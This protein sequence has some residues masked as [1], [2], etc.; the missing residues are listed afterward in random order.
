M[1]TRPQAFCRL[2]L[3]IVIFLLFGLTNSI[4]LP[5]HKA[6]DEIAHFQYTRFIAQHGR[7]PQNYEERAEA[8]YRSDWPAL[9]H[10]VA[11][12]LTGWA[13]SNEPPYLK[14]VWESPRF[15]LARELLDTKRLANTEDEFWPYRGAVLM[16]HLGRLVSLGLA[17]GAIVIVF[18][19]AL[20]VFPNNYQAAVTAAALVAF[21]PTF[22]FIS[23]AMSDD[24]LLALVVGLYTLALIKIFK[25]STRLLS[26]AALGGLMGLSAATKYSAVILP[27]EVLALA[28]YLVWRARWSL[29][30]VLGRVGMAA[31][32]AIIASSWW[33]I[34]LVIY[35]NEIAE[36]GPVVGALKPVIAGG[37]DRSQRYA[38]YV[39][40]G[41]QIGISDSPE[42]ISE[43]FDAWLRQTFQSFWAI[44]VGNYPLSP[45]AYLFVGVILL[46]A[47]VGLARI[48]QHQPAYRRWIGLFLGHMGVF[49]VFPLVRYGILRDLG[50]SAQGRHLLFPVATIFPLLLW[51]GWQGL[52]RF[53]QRFLPAVTIAGLLLWNIAL[54]VRVA[55][56]YDN[57][58]TWLPV[59]TVSTVT[60]SITQP[61]DVP[62]GNHLRLLGYDARL[63]PNQSALALSFYW[64]AASYPDE[65]Y[66]RD[67]RL[68]QSGVPQLVWSTYPANARYPTRLWEPE[69]VIRDDVLLPLSGLEAGDYTLQ[70]Q[71]R[72]A[73][74]PL[75]AL[76]AAPAL[77]LTTLALPAMPPP[78]PNLPLNITIDGREVIGGVHLWQASAYTK[79]DLPEYNPRMTIPLLW[80]SNLASTQRVNWLLIDPA[81]Q[82]YPATTVTPNQIFFQVMPFW[83]SGLYRLRAELWQAE[84]VIASAETPPALRVFNERPR[85]GQLPLA[86]RLVGAS[87]DNKLN[88]LGYDLP[89]RRLEPGQELPVTLY[90]Q[91][92]RT[93]DRSYTVFAKLLD[94]QHQMQS[95]VER[96]PADGYNTI[97]WLEG[98]M[99]VD[100]FAL[101]VPS[102]MPPGVYWLNVGVYD[103]ISGQAVSLPISG[104]DGPS[105]GETSITLDAVKIGGPPPGVVA[106][107]IT[108]AYPQKI[109]F[110]DVI[111]LRGYDVQYTG[112]AVGLTFYWKSLAQTNIDYTVFVHLQNAGGAI[113]AQQDRPLADGVYPSSLWT[114]GE[115]IPDSLALSV[116]AGLPPGTYTIV[117]GLY[118]FAAGRRLPVAVTGKDTITVTT[119]TL[120]VD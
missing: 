67:I 54:T 33:Y 2:G 43:P 48:W 16:W 101:P 68:V 6:P 1:I 12:F 77:T 22:N 116:P 47:A 112:Q 7:L 73:A 15:E 13:D 18:I 74:G 20:Q 62:F 110:G 104:E 70:L 106:S 120:P 56:Y 109:N 114:P 117:A 96:L 115:I 24:S 90:W 53:W 37:V 59:R 4:L 23:S 31:V 38:A 51:L 50:Q 14:F 58:H 19:T 34:F 11:A 5:L 89:V 93:M 60:E 79:L 21:L 27:V 91:G 46:C 82:P 44:N 66:R 10:V 36:Y 55:T 108:P 86:G 80:H 65:D 76:N 72:N 8:G 30:R 85:L 78:P 107:T 57:I 9:Y 98:E 102:N 81:G 45:A 83:P 100:G 32:A 64:R 87:F 49:M 103:Q 63:Q 119:L 75:P 28:G 99:V 94:H 41:G 69:E 88:L 26:F 39:L 3:I 42:F 29:P 95:L 17:A 92:V 118:D 52:P 111:S 105:A 84:Q 25:G 61:L 35:F 40:T 97:Y 113:V 71:I